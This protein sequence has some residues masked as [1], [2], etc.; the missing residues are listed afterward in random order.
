MI[1][2]Q[3]G[4]YPSREIN[5]LTYEDKRTMEFYVSTY[6]YTHW[7]DQEQIVINNERPN[8]FGKKY[9]SPEHYVRIYNG[10]EE[11]E[12]PPLKI[13]NCL[14]LI[15]KL[16]DYFLKR[17][18]Q[19]ENAFELSRLQE[20]IRTRIDKF[21]EKL[22]SKILAIGRKKYMHEKTKERKI[23]EIYDNQLKPFLEE[24]KAANYKGKFLKWEMA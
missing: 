22:C 19:Y 12:T 20:S 15:K 9:F 21:H 4:I 10:D 8:F 3:P 24:L 16:P 17:F 5:L 6:N 11:R 23:N 1:D 2:S 13:I 14:P 18:G 7:K